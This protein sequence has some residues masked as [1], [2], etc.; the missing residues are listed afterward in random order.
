MGL[1]GQREAGSRKSQPGSPGDTRQM[2]P[3][4][5]RR[6]GESSCGKSYKSA[7]IDF[8]SSILLPAVPDKLKG[9]SQQFRP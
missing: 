2:P 7:Q 5:P 1:T 4:L 9:D 8:R 6:A 3:T